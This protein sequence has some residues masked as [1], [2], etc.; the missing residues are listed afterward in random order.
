MLVSDVVENYPNNT[1]MKALL[2]EREFSYKIIDSMSSP[3]FVKTHFALSVMPNILKSGCK[4][5]ILYNI[6]M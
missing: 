2:L 6:K 5:N 1:D 4:V 3:R